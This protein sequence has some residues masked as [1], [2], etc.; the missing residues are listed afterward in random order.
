MLNT[1]SV[2]DSLA[3]A[4]EPVWGSDRHLVAARLHLHPV[5]PTG[6]DAAHFME[7]LG[8]HW[9]EEAPT[10]I[11]AVASPRLLLQTLA[12]DP[13]HNTCI[14]V[15]ADLLARADT[16][17]RLA[18]ATRRGHKLVCRTPLSGLYGP[19]MDNVEARP[20]VHLSADEAQRLLAPAP[21]GRPVAPLPA[22][23]IVGDVDSRTLL[24]HLLEEQS[25]HGVLGWP[26][27]DVLE[28]HRHHPISYDRDI[29]HAVLQAIDDDD[30]SIERLE[31][32]VR[33]DAV[34]VYRILLLVNSAAY[35]NR[36]EIGSLRHALMM[37]GFRE[38]G[39]WVTEQITEVEPDPDLHPVRLAMVMRARLAQHLLMTG[40]DD[41][42]RA[43]VYTTALMGELGRLLHQPLPVLLNRLPLPG[44]VFD[45]LLRRDGPYFPLVDTARAMG[46][47][48][49]IARLALVCRVHD[50]SLET[51]NRSLLRMLATS[52]SHSGRRSERMT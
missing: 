51:A 11:L 16:A 5:T 13:V 3:L 2:L 19:G 32:L 17:A 1:Q 23:L 43:E 12:V 26:E 52:H 49:D 42:L 44:R 20:L 9:P 31:R 50:I 29:L 38:L 46:Q 7:L 48:A 25:V 21:P 22:G 34:L 8:E 24:R 10:L 45:A 4:Y 37:L 41:T 39:R 47:P 28:A 6:V 36:R 14:E 35:G 15:P 33:Q 40:S 30:C 27:D 18:I